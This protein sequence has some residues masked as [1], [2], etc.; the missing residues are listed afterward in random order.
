MSEGPCRR[1]YSPMSGHIHEGSRSLVILSLNVAFGFCALLRFSP[2]SFSASYH[3]ALS[4]SLSLA[5]S[6]LLRD[7][8]PSFQRQLFLLSLLNLLYVGARGWTRQRNPFLLPYVTKL[9]LT[10]TKVRESIEE[11]ARERALTIWYR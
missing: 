1:P 11:T 6:Y 10:V 5:T 2:S 8:L 3:S 4:L 7:L 9:P